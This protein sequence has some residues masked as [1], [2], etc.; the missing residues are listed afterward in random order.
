MDI[1]CTNDH[2]SCFFFFRSSIRTPYGSPRVCF[3]PTRTCPR[4]LL[5]SNWFLYLLYAFYFFP[6][7]NSRLATCS[8][9]E[10]RHRYRFTLT[11][12]VLQPRSVQESS[13]I[14]GCRAIIVSSP[15]RIYDNSHCSL[16]IKGQTVP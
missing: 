11:T 12:I 16:K 10:C 6:F 1:L 2:W 4:S 8:K 7:Q 9:I 14:G 3:K 15:F 5:P 13:D